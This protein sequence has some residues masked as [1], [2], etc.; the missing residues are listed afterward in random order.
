[1]LAVPKVLSAFFQQNTSIEQRSKVPSSSSPSLSPLSSPE[2]A[3]PTS[4]SSSS[5]PPPPS[6]EK[7]IAEDLSKLNTK[8]VQQAVSLAQVATDMQQHQ[9]TTALEVYLLAVEKMITA[10]P[11]ETDADVREA[12][13]SKLE[14]CNVIDRQQCVY[15]AGDGPGTAGVIESIIVFAA[16]A[17]KRSPIPKMLACCFAYVLAGLQS[18]DEALCIRQR[19][20]RIT[21]QGFQKVVEID[22]QFRIHQVILNAFYAVLLSLYKAG[23][24]YAEA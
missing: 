3:L 8:Q 14:R 9:W 2:D 7:V 11:L 21:T 18:L 19:A 22:Q 12:L 15:R 5:S 16:I 13:V 24:A 17:L 4:S 6:Y 1:M 20:W 10:L 23:L